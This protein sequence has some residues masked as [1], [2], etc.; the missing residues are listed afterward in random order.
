MPTS[1]TAPNSCLVELKSLVNDVVIALKASSLVARFH[2]RW[3]IIPVCVQSESE[4]CKA[5]RLSRILPFIFYFLYFIRGNCWF[6]FFV[7]GPRRDI[8]PHLRSIFCALRPFVLLLLSWFNVFIYFLCCC[9]S[10]STRRKPSNE[11]ISKCRSM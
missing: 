8:T 5:W 7:L 11:Y 1:A 9:C 4:R 6:F 10:F 2:L 3:N